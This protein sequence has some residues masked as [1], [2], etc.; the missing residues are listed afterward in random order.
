MDTPAATDELARLAFK[1]A[2]PACADQSGIPEALR[3]ALLDS[4]QRWRDL[5][6]LSADLVFETDAEGRFVFISPDT[7]LG[8]AAST[9][10]GQP[11]ELL[12]AEPEQARVFNPFRPNATVRRRRAWLRPRRCGGGLSQLRINAAV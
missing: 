7:T 12:L 9:L 4:R 3:R 2:A 8:W 1:E 6:T 11:A 10:L 5:V